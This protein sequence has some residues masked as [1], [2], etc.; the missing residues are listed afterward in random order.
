[1]EPQGYPVS[2]SFL[3]ALITCVQGQ[4]QLFTYVPVFQLGS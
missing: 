1:M 2:A 4:V 3:S